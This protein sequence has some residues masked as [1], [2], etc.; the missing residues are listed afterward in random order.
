MKKV[1]YSTRYSKTSKPDKYGRW[2]R[3]AY[4]TRNNKETARDPIMDAITIAW[5]SRT[6]Y[7]IPSSTGKKTAKPQV[8]FQVICYFPTSGQINGCNSSQQKTYK[9]AQKWL[10]MK[11]KYFNNFLSK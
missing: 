3:R 1:F 9:A 8:S 2:G 5:I 6:E 4:V 11:W 7:T 10:E